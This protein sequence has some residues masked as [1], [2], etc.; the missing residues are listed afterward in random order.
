MESAAQTR[1]KMPRS[2]IGT[3]PPRLR[4]GLAIAI[5]LR[6]RVPYRPMLLG[7]SELAMLLH[8]FKGSRLA[9][10]SRFRVH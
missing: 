1:P 3:G 7:R 6:P 2:R 9:E 4:K 8:S 10:L 5:L